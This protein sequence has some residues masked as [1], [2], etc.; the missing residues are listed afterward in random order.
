MVD[1]AKPL[2]ASE[3]RPSVLSLSKSV[4]H[5]ALGTLWLW[6]RWRTKALA[7]LERALVADPVN[8]SSGDIMR[9]FSTK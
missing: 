1:E 6:L 9:S 5:F 7:C 8:R 3:E 2:A 4:W